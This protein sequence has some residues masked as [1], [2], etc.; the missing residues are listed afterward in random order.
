MAKNG[1][2]GVGGV[3]KK[4]GKY[5]IGDE[6]G[7]ARKVTK[8][9]IGDKNGVARLCYQAHEHS[10]IAY[11]WVYS[12]LNHCYPLTRCSCGEEAVGSPK[13]HVGEYDKE[14]IREQTCQYYAIWEYT[15]S[16]CGSR[17]RKAGANPSDHVANAEATCIDPSLCKWCGKVLAMPTGKHIYKGGVCVNCG[18]PQS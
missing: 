8:A 4:I 18:I 7:V 16:R 15:C 11:R 14:V 12:D 6:N 5:Y 1:Y 10:F 3:A 2:I 13:S 17:Y 9:Y